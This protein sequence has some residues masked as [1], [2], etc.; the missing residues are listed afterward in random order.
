[1]NPYYQE[2]N[3]VSSIQSRLDGY[4][5]I[6]AHI[7]IEMWYP[8]NRMR[9]GIHIAASLLAVFLLVRPFDCFAGAITREA[10]ECC[11]KGKCLPTKDA[12][13]CCK[14]TVPGG[15]QLAASKAPEHSVPAFDVATVD[16]QSSMSLPFVAAL[17]REAHSPPG[18]P[19]HARLNLPLLI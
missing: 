15:T 14:G 5:K 7:P 10:A 4:A 16:I 11:T 2:S 12:H 19:P 18:L 3:P 1:M 6:C 13:E 8:V 17:F 9:R